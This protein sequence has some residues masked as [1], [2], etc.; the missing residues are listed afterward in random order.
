VKDGF[1]RLSTKSGVLMG[2]D[3]SFNTRFG[4]EEGTNPEELIGAA[5]AGCFSMALAA[6]LERARFKVTSITTKDR[7]HIDPDGDG[8]RIKKIEIET[9][10]I[11][12]DIDEDTF[13]DF[14]DDV[15]ETCPVSKAL[16]GV[17][18]EL[19]TKCLQCREAKQK[20]EEAIAM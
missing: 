1:G 16:A 5:H 11:V 20:E 15:K 8:F 7:V 18:F 2:T 9:V 6:A 3:Y 19:T 14:A 12:D 13:R 10:G 4:S 17:G